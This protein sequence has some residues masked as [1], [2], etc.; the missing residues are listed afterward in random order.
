VGVPRQGAPFE[1][2]K[3]VIYIL[4]IKR[5]IVTDHVMVACCHRIGA[6]LIALRRFH[7]EWKTTGRHSIWWDEVRETD[8]V[9]TRN[10]CLRNK[11]RDSPDELKLMRHFLVQINKGQ[12]GKNTNRILLDLMDYGDKVPTPEEFSD[13]PLHTWVDK[14]SSV[15]IHEADFYDYRKFSEVHLPVRIKNKWVMLV[16]DP[17]IRSY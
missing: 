5:V 4:D 6:F 17:K 2:A 16:C 1:K 8:P 14:V 12:R 10:L 13:F 15:T 7:S 9:Y 11:L 3:M